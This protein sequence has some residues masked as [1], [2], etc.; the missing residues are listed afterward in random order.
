MAMMMDRISRGFTELSGEARLR[1]T[2]YGFK[3]H[4]NLYIALGGID[5]PILWGLQ[6]NQNSSN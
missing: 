3:H 1:E 5:H 4:P 2:G 6:G